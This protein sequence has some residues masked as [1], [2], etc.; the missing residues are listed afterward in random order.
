M[1]SVHKPGYDLDTVR[2]VALAYRRE[3]Q[4]G[5]L[6]EPAREAAKAAF[7]ARHLE[8]VV[9]LKRMVPAKRHRSTG[10]GTSGTILPGPAVARAC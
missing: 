1:Y 9:R 7:R 3:R 8:L 6:D 10:R 5:R 4:A 2:A